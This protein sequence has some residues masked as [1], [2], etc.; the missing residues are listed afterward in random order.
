MLGDQPRN[1][2][3]IFINTKGELTYKKKFHVLG[4]LEDIREVYRNQ[5]DLKGKLIMLSPDFN[6]PYERQME[7]FCKFLLNKQ[8]ANP[9][10]TVYLMIDEINEYQ[11]S[12]SVKQYLRALFIMGLSLGVR[13]IVTSQRYSLVH[14]H[15]RNNCEVFITFKQVQQDLDTMY[16][17]GYI[18]D[19]ELDFSQK[20][21]AYGRRG[22]NKN[23]KVIQ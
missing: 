18:N 12:R 19:P 14:P 1:S 20:Y 6:Q 11:T 4:S 3:K 2:L 15:I 7:K 16:Q 22:L 10:L 8:R 21:R 17:M 23:I 9:F 5:K 13:V